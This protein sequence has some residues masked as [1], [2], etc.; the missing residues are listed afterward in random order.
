MTS[1]AAVGDAVATGGSAAK[2]VV[3]A[4]VV[5]VVVVKSGIGSCE[6]VTTCAPFCV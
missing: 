6:K 2:V 5:V 4:G 1:E 3:G